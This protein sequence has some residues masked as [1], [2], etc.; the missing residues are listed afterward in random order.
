MVERLYSEYPELY[1]VIQSEW[2]YDRDIAFVSDRLAGHTPSETR[3]LEIGCG[4]GE[5]TRRFVEEGFDVTAVEPV[6]G[7]LSLAREKTTAR[8]RQCGLPDPDVD[9]KFDVIVA[10]RGVIN[11]IPPED[12]AP[13][14]EALEAHLA[15][16]GVLVFDNSPLPPDG[17]HPALDIGA[18]DQGNYAR[19]VQMNPTEEG[20]LSW[21]S[22]VFTPDGEFFIDSY[23]MTPFEDLT[24]A[25]A[26]AELGLSVE[27]TDGYG[28]DDRRTVFVARA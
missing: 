21:D 25:A 19:I 23:E 26:L 9:G 24:I 17:N 13:A 16:G 8:F 6:E 4:T 14:L 20:R 12:L 3:L 18:T 1:D 7:M 22:V 10:I 2:D 28:P 5:H 15:D 11:H 27:P